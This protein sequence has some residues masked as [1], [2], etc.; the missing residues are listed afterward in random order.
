MDGQRTQESQG[1]PIEVLCAVQLAFASLA[2]ALIATPLRPGVLKPHLLGFLILGM[3][4][5][6]LFTSFLLIMI[7]RGQNWARLVFIGFFVIG[8]PFAFPAILQAIPKSP[9]MALASL[10]QLSLQMMAVVLLLQQPARNWF[11]RVK[12][13]KLMNLQVT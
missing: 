6:L 12:L 2:V 8:L 7:L 10:I 9:L 13:Q 11:K 1:R 5:T 3:V 4:L